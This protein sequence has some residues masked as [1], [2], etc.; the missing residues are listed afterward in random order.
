MDQTIA[1]LKQLLAASPSKDNVLRRNILKEYFQVLV[2]DFIYSHKE[3]SQLFFY[4]GSCLAHCYGLPR[5]SEDLDFVDVKMNI[6][7]EAFSKD[8]QEYVKKET[9]IALKAVCQKFRVYLKFPILHTL[10]LATASESDLLFLKVE[11]F[12]D[13]GFCMSFKTE[14]I[15]VFKL[16]RSII[17]RTFDLPTLMSTKIRAVLL[18]KW[19]KKDTSG[20][21]VA[22]VKGRDYF[23]L[24]W[25]LEKSVTPNLECIP[26]ANGLEDLKSKLLAV[27][28]RVDTKSIRV[29]LE[30]LIDNRQFVETISANMKSI[31]EKGIQKL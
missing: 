28:S 25:Y 21:V 13:P 7:L 11:I 6:H 14:Y 22:T 17:V 12:R 10:G 2:L 26:E 27:I 5:L 1:V 23:D 9:G 19:E 3:Y 24:M 30:A 16:N 4:G 15:P 18:R 8:V 31:I 29:D 20:N